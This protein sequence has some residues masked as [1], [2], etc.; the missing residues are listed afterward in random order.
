MCGNPNVTIERE[1]MFCRLRGDK[2]RVELDVS[3]VETLGEFV[4]ERERKS[5][6][7]GEQY[8]QIG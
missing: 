7:V 2:G 4:A 6:R 5:E 3:L 8:D 1:I